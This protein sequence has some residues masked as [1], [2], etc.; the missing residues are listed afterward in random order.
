MIPDQVFR[1]SQG[2]G[3]GD[4]FQFRRREHPCP[5]RNDRIRRAEDRHM[6][7]CVLRPVVRFHPGAK[8][9]F[10]QDHFLEQERGNIEFRDGPVIPQVFQIEHD[11]VALGHAVCDLI[12]NRF[13]AE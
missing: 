11:K 2:Y 10:A 1:S 7:A 4:G 5:G 9:L 3:A 13:H 8:V 12:R 6:M